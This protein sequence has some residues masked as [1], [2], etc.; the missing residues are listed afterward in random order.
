MNKKYIV[1]LDQGTTSSRAVIF[2]SEQKIVGVAQK[3]FKQ[4]Y[5]KEGKRKFKLAVC[6]GANRW[7]NYR[8]SFRSCN[9]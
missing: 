6:L 7:T 9:I 8:C 1:A 5:P 2:D 3:E 4:I